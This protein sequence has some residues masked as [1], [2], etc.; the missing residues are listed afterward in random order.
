MEPF[1][2]GFSLTAVAALVLYILF[3]KQIAAVYDKLDSRVHAVE[4]TIA[5]HTATLTAHETKL[6]E[7]TTEIAAAHQSANDAKV[8]AAKPPAA[9]AAA[10]AAS[11]TH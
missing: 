2:I 8:A 5:G 10:P 4:G 3:H 7:H 6:G 1:L 9:T 11:G